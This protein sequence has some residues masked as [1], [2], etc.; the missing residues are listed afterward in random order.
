MTSKE[1]LEAAI[2][3]AIGNGWKPPFP[4][5]E[6]YLPRLNWIEFNDSSARHVSMEPLTLL[7]NHGFAK[8]LWGTKPWHHRAIVYGHPGGWAG[9]EP[10]D[11]DVTIEETYSLSNYQYHLQQMALVDDPI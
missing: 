8:A 5:V 10:V 6:V 2:S 4:N 3:K 9:S 7:F 11:A 1:T